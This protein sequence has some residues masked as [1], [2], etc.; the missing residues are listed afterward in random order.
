MGKEPKP[1]KNELNQ[2]PAFA[3]NRTQTRK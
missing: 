1:S 2:N 3:M